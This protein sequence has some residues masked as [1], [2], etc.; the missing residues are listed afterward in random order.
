MPL[1]I[2]LNNVINCAKQ[3][4]SGHPVNLGGGVTAKLNRGKMTLIE[5]GRDVFCMKVRIHGNILYVDYP[6]TVD[7]EGGRGWG[8][9]GMLLT[10]RYA[11]EQGC[12]RVAADTQLELDSYGYWVRFGIQFSIPSDLTKAIVKAMRWIHEKIPQPS[13][14]GTSVMVI[15]DRKKPLTKRKKRS[16]SFSFS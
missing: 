6:R 9:L 2:E 4:Q 13:A 10:L 8:H 11:L 16:N 5:L 12:S 3:L 1:S 7:G 15:L 14:R